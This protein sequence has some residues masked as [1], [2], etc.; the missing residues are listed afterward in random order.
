MITGGEGN[1]K[2][3]KVHE[4]DFREVCNELVV[5]IEFSLSFIESNA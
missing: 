2:S 4:T 3:S 1:L 5:L